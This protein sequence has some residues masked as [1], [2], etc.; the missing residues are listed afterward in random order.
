MLR[1]HFR[2][3]RDKQ[4]WWQTNFHVLSMFSLHVYT[5]FHVGSPICEVGNIP[6]LMNDIQ[7]LFF[8]CFGDFLSC[9]GVEVMKKIANA[10]IQQSILLIL[11]RC[12][13]VL[14]Q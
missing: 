12:K 9:L 6:L 7:I 4:W 13:K 11:R 10:Y 5:V 1:E 3:Y 2:E 14:V 8:F